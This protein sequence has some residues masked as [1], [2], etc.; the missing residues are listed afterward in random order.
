[1]VLLPPEQNFPIIPALGTGQ[2]AL[3][4]LG[5]P[6]PFYQLPSSRS[7]QDV[8]SAPPPWSLLWLVHLLNLILT[9]HP[10]ACTGSHPQPSHGSVGRRSCPSLGQGA[11][12]VRGIQEGKA[13]GGDRCSVREERQGDEGDRGR[14]GGGREEEEEET[15]GGGWASQPAVLIGLN[16]VPGQQVIRA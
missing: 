11:G 12:S 15:K 10:P 1:M 8:P 14:N 6:G 13:E 2:A 9:S 4:P 5:S 16:T 3:S 7:I